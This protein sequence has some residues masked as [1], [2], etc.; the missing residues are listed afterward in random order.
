MVTNKILILCFV[1]LAVAVTLY[2]LI[3]PL[4]AQSARANERRL[5]IVRGEARKATASRDTE[6]AARR[7]R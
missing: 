6:A 3:S 4:L 2:I 1:A 7:K 5:A